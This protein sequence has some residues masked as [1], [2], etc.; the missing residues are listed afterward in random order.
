MKTYQDL[1]KIFDLAIGR[2]DAANKFYADLARRA[3]NRTVQEVFNALAKEELGH[4]SLLMTLKVEPG[5][6]AKFKPAA[7]YHVAETEVQ[8]E[9]STTMPL[10]DAVA[11]AMKKEEQA[12]MLY[13][14]LG[15]AATTP[16]VKALFEDLMNME[17]GH[18]NRLEALFVD[19][20]Y[21]EVF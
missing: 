9:V 8:P 15:E 4:K 5:V 3:T 21:P 14:A 6:H 7:D 18:K 2:E 20:G 10:R 16:E 11:L 17:S 12:V 1:G 13:M 19:I